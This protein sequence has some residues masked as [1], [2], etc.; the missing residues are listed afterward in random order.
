MNEETGEVTPVHYYTFDEAAD[1][2]AVDS[3]TGKKD[4]TKT[5]G[6]GSA[7]GKAGKAAQFDGS[8]YIDV[9]DKTILN[10]E[11]FTVTAWINWEGGRIN[12]I[13]ATSVSGIVEGTG[14]LFYV[15]GDGDGVIKAGDG[16]GGEFNS[17]GK[18]TPN[19]WTHVA[20][21]KSGNT[22]KLYI[23]GQADGEADNSQTG[24]SQRVIRIGANHNTDAHNF[25]GAIDELKI[26]D[27]ALTAEQ[28]TAAMEVPPENSSL[29]TRETTIADADWGKHELTIEANLVKG[30]SIS[31]VTN[32]GSD[33]LTGENGMS[34]SGNIITLNSDFFKAY[35]E[36]I[37]TVGL[38]VTFAKGG[39]DTFT[40][41]RGDPTKR[42]GW[43]LQKQAEDVYAAIPEAGSPRRTTASL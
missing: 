5:S 24:T 8:S 43:S 29:K 1:A 38:E 39:T 35:S 7:D 4:G 18:I 25:H 19:E 16:V 22:A 30:D 42:F 41:K 3:G 21:V 28:I 23:N 34:I 10:G 13:L 33:K 26:F 9:D 40:I 2:A 12:T 27:Q 6:I 15:H 32:V 31:E 37:R 11:N 36:D 20:F 17:T 14:L